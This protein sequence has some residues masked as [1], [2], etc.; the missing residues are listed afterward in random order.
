MRIVLRR[1]SVVKP[2]IVRDAV[3]RVQGAYIKV[4]EWSLTTSDTTVLGHSTTYQLVWLLATR[5]VHANPNDI[6]PF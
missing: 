1:L 3:Q 5:I 2:V 4:T 6:K